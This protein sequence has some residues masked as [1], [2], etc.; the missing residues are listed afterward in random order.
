MESEMNMA[1]RNLNTKLSF[2]SHY[3]LYICQFVFPY[4]VVSVLH[5]TLKSSRAI[6]HASTESAFGVSE[7]V[8]VCVSAVKS[9]NHTWYTCQP[10]DGRNLLAR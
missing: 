5:F 4:L 8:S 10:A 9:P 2:L 6:S 1:H 3:Q 7:T